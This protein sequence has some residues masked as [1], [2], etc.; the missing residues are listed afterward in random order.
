LVLA[1][2]IGARAERRAGDARALAHFVSH[3][4][5]RIGTM[6]KRLFRQVLRDRRLLRTAAGA[7]ATGAAGSVGTALLLPATC[8]G[9]SGFAAAG[10][11]RTGRAGLI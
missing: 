5:A 7:T 11:W 4:R 8:F 9:R 10:F 1:V 2:E 3:L 6:I